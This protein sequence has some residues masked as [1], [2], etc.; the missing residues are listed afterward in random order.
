MGAHQ[1]REQAIVLGLHAVYGV[2]VM[3]LTGH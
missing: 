1:R 2:V 3:E